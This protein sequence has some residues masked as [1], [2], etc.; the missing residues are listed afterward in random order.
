MV[1]RLGGRL[2][3]GR[4]RGGGHAHIIGENMRMAKGKKP[5]RIKGLGAFAPFALGL[6][7]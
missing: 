4:W 3:G 2:L 7:A 5:F 6:I 1:G